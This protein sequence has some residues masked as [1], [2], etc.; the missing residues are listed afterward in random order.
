MESTL[1]KVLKKAFASKSGKTELKTSGKRRIDY[2]NP[3]RR[4]VGEIERNRRIKEALLRLKT[5]KTIHKVL[6]VPQRDFDKAITMA[7][8]LKMKV[9]ITNLKGNKRKTVK[10]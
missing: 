5:K 7:R 3:K 1:H 9:T 8:Q 6:R 10:S 4:E 2:L